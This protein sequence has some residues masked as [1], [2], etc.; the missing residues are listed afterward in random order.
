MGPRPSRPAIARVV[1]L[2]ALSGLVLGACRSSPDLGEHG[3]WGRTTA[4]LIAAPEQYR[5]STLG[6]K[7]LILTFDD[8]PNAGAITNDLSAWLKNRPNPIH[9]TFFV[10]GA[11]IAATALTPNDSCGEPFPDAL[12]TLAQVRQDGHLVG[13]HTTTHRDLTTLTAAERIQEVTD[14]DTSIAPFVPWNRFLFR[15]PFGYWDAT[16]QAALSGSAM[17]KYIGPIYWNA[18]GGP[19]TD[20]QAADWECWQNGLTTRACGDRYLTEIRAV[21][22]GIVL[23]HERSTFMNSANHDLDNGVGNSQDMVKYIVPILEGEGFTFKALDEDPEVRAALPSCNAACATCSGP[24]ENQC[25][26]CAGG[27]FLSD[28]TCKPCAP[29]AAGTFQ[30]AAC[31]SGPAACSAC[32]V[33]APG[34]FQATACAAAAN[35]VCTACGSGTFSSEPG[36][37]TCKSCGDC[38]DGDACTTDACSPTVGCTHTPIVGCG[39]SGTLSNAQPG[40]PPTG[41]SGTAKSGG[42]GCS[43]G[44]AALP[45]RTSSSRMTAALLVA[46]AFVRRRSGR[47]R[48]SRARG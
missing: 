7:E 34:T 46:L 28:G 14:T 16:V 8:G 15:A 22:K 17:S 35:T 33:C 5:G 12:A 45:A 23:M 1:A 32:S 27:S 38:N 21:G 10:N 4:E 40:A 31:G 39:P 9:A 26:T 18:G 13:N 24:G 25:T 3:R 47:A 6:A 43:A 41:D 36:A 48:A 20:T 29:C 42:G 30:T 2:S 44:S 37:A 19:T 11:C